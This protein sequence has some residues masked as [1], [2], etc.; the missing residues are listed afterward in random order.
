[1]PAKRTLQKSRY[2]LLLKLDLFKKNATTVT[3]HAP[4]A[5]DLCKREDHKNPSIP[6]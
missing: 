2:V 4:F 5:L 1:M 6:I 3:V